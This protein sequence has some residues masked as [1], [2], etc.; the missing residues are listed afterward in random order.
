MLKPTLQ[1]TLERFSHAIQNLCSRVLL[2]ACRF[3]FL[4]YFI[5]II[6]IIFFESLYRAGD[7]K[8]F[9]CHREL[10]TRCHCCWKIPPLPTLLAIWQEPEGRTEVRIHDIQTGGQGDRLGIKLLVVVTTWTFYR[11]VASSL[12]NTSASCCTI[13]YTP[14][15]P[16]LHA[17]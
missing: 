15:F 17:W 2:L 9:R 7:F 12:R 16:F 14:G 4:F 6:I 11:K 13:W 8:S 3:I 1:W 5:I 10:E